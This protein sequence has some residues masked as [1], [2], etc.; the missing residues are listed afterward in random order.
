MRQFHT[1]THLLLI[2]SIN[3]GL[4]VPGWNGKEAVHFRHRF[5]RIEL[6]KENGKG[7]FLFFTIWRHLWKLFGW[8][9]TDS[10]RLLRHFH[11]SRD[12]QE[13]VNRQTD[14]KSRSAHFC[15]TQIPVAFVKFFRSCLFTLLSPRWPIL[16]PA[17]YFY[18]PSETWPTINNHWCAILGVL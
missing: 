11:L 8:R 13:K 10:Q 7:T 6:R 9:R 17:S 15:C 1:V 12:A 2:D 16:P 5:Y 3:L 14:K 4:L 18:S